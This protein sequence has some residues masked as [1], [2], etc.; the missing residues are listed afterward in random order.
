[1]RVRLRA[2]ATVDVLFEGY[3]NKG[4]EERTASTV[5]LIRDA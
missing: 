5:S 3:A 1:M 4:P 2:M